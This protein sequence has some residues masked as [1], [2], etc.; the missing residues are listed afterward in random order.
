MCSIADIAMI[1][2]TFTN[3]HSST[4][5]N[6]NTHTSVN[7][8]SMT[9]PLIQKP[10][11]ELMKR[12]SS[13]SLNKLIEKRNPSTNMLKAPLNVREQ[14]LMVEETKECR[15]KKILVVDDNNFNIMAI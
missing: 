12:S 13:S 6:L 10:R 5:H 7:Q 11:K 4:V 1:N 8:L 14:I 3:I 9:L 2:N 15:C